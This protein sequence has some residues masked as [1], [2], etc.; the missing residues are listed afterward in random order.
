MSGVCSERGACFVGEGIFTWL[1]SWLVYSGHAVLELLSLSGQVL[2]GFIDFLCM[3][4]LVVIR[5]ALLHSGSLLVANGVPTKRR[6]IP[7]TIVG[8]LH[9]FLR[10]HHELFAHF[11]GG[12]IALLFITWLC[13]K[14]W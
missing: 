7:D 10:R 14:I 9:G 4:S 8:A 13:V 6:D 12:V 1:I 11:L 5:V 3:V 2:N